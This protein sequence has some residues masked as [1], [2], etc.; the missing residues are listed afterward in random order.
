MGMV[1]LA[2]WWTVHQN[3]VLLRRLRC[4]YCHAA[5]YP[6]NFWGWGGED[7]ELGKRLKEN[8]IEIIR[9]GPELEGSIT[10]L[11]VVV[12]A[13]VGTEEACVIAVT[14]TVPL[15]SR[16]RSSWSRSNRCCYRVVVGLVCDGHCRQGR[17]SRVDD[18]GGWVH[19]VP[20]HD[21]VRAA[22]Q[23]RRDV[24][25]QRHQQPRVHAARGP[26]ACTTRS[27]VGADPGGPVWRGRP[28]LAQNGRGVGADEGTVRRAAG[29]G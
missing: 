17:A 21:Q 15:M 23:A 2:R 20:Q 7:D 10:D 13:E 11:E 26:H 28:G 6:N 18:E 9:P 4:R 1:P 5:R 25:V 3:A 19:Q 24:A 27:A 16:S 14:M 8:R 29:C 22:E 12:T